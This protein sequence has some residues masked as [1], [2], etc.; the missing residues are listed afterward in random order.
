MPI[1]PEDMTASVSDE[2]IAA[3]TNNGIKSD[4]SIS[5][6]G[7]EDALRQRC[8]LLGIEWCPQAPKASAD[9]VSLISA[10]LAVRLRVVPVRLEGNRL[11]VAMLDP[12]DIASADEIG[13]LVGR[14]I[15][16]IGLPK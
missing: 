10:D 5:A 6:G 13:T 2:A 7:E 4:A 15:T 1:S 3:H 9:A 11:V 8:A 16:R 14:P 12:L